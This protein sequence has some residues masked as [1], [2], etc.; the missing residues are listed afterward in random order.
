MTTDPTPQ[1]LPIDRPRYLQETPDGWQSGE[2][3]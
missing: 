1:G 2:G 3:E